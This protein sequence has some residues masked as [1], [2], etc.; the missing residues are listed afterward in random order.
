M[1]MTTMKLR[2]RT[3]TA[4]LGVLAVAATSAGCSGPDRKPGGAAR[5]AAAQA[6]EASVPAGWV[7]H[8]SPGI[9]VAL[10]PDWVP[11]PAE[12]RGAPGAAMEV[13]VPYTGQPTPPPLFLGLVERGRVG[14]LGPR[15]QVLRLQLKAQLPGATLGEAR[16]VE[17]VGGTDAVSFDVTYQD[18]G[19][20][21]VLDT[22][23]TPVG[24][25]SRQLI[26]ET[27]GLPKFGFWFGATDADFD[28][29]T[30]TGILR[31]LVVNPSEVAPDQPARTVAAGP[32]G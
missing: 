21:S 26:V 8:T 14:P 7:V 25:R 32:T 15:E 17:V 22:P 29:A 31:S 9:R 23:M 19:G 3:V 6:N 13:G 16:H 2:I 27:P 5:S 12:Q 4:V 10:P 1:T 18:A 30:W 11:R 24:M 28:E 20:T